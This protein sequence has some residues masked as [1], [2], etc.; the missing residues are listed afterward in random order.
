MD[1]RWGMRIAVDLGV[2]LLYLPRTIGIGRL[3]NISVSGALVRS[4]FAPPL[5]ARIRVARGPGDL[6][7]V[8]WD[9]IEGHV[10]RHHRE[11]FGLEWAELAPVG[12][13]TLLVESSRSRG[14]G[15][16]SPQLICTRNDFPAQL[17]RRLRGNG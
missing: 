7:G 13:C 15:L 16:T 9:A 8:Q 6:A 17:D 12:I 1:H 5:C 3:V 4:G 2:Q 11:G 14:R 10:V